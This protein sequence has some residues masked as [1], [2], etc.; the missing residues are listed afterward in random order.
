M[1]RFQFHVDQKICKFGLLFSHW[2][3]TYFLF[4]MAISHFVACLKH[5]WHVYHVV[6]LGN[7]QISKTKVGFTL[8]LHK[9]TD[10]Y[11]HQ[12]LISNSVCSF[13]FFQVVVSGVPGFLQFLWYP[14]TAGPVIPDGTHHVYHHRLL[15]LPPVLRRQW[16]GFTFLRILSGQTWRHAWRH[17]TH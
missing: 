2:H 10:I 4:S 12:V 9:D 3:T 13:L 1:C 5:S 14:A 16:S 8:I 6:D 11:P 7:F 17:Q 15:Y